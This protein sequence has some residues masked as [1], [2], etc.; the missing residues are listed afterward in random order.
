KAW[1]NTV[2]WKVIGE[3]YAMAKAGTLGV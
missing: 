1:W 3:R 2:N